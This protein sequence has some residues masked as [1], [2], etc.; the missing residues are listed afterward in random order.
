M[1]AVLDAIR[2]NLRKIQIVFEPTESSFKT[3]TKQTGDAKEL[4]VRQF[5]ES[6]FPATYRVRRGLIYSLD[7]SSREIDCVLLAP[8]H[9]PLVTP[10]REVIVAEGVHAAIE[11]KPDISTLSPNSE[12]YRGLMQV[13]SVKRLKREVAH[14]PTNELPPDHKIPCAIFSAKSRPHHEIVNFMLSQV[15][16][17][18]LLPIE[19]PDIIITLDN[20]LLFHSASLQTSMFR[21][22]LALKKPN[23]AKQG[24]IHF[25]PEH[26]TLALLLLILYSVTPPEPHF[27]DPILKKYL[28]FC[29]DEARLFEYCL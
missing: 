7:G 26:D 1:S 16:S 11:V 2:E 21:K 12:F 17:N 29:A 18:A 22:F 4:T 6:F 8:N 15:N 23:H 10:V 27:T 5:L 3:D 19:L 24:F 25:G 9:P 20:G 13:Q 28:G 14:L